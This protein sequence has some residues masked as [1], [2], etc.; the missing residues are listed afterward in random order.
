MPYIIIYNSIYIYIYIYDN[1]I[2]YHNRCFNLFILHNNSFD[3]QGS[4]INK[5]YI[6]TF[7]Y[8]IRLFLLTV[9][10]VNNDK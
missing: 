10:T 2:V 9:L 6:F 1:Q 5:D 8:K 3:N 7:L 4:K